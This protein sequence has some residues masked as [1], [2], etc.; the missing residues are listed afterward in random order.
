M[1]CSVIVPVYNHERAIGSVVEQL[2]PYGL[3]CYLINDGSS[4]LCSAVLRDLAGRENHWLTL[5]ERRANGGKG[6]A[7]IDGM[8]R[9]FADGFSHALQIDADG[10]HDLADI[11]RFVASAE[12]YPDRMILG[13][14]CFD[15]NAPKGRV[16]GRRLTNVWIWINTLSLAIGDGMCGF[17]C[18]PLAAV[19]RLLI[20]ARLGQRMDFDIDIA[21]RLYWQGVEVVNL[22][23]QVRYPVDGVSHFKMLQ[24]NL[25]ISRKHAELFFGMLWRAPELLARRWQ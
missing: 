4:E 14:P 19:E 16:Y 13:R 9:A 21:V 23:T 3:S 22:D 7:V 24:D 5:L 8:R 11:Q 17:R 6:A 20:G 10:Q 2:K 18:Y 1:K 25:M 15:E 12:R